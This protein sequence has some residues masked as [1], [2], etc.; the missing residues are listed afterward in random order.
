MLRVSNRVVWGTAVVA[1]AARIAACLLL[2]GVARA[3]ETAH[4]HGDLA[5]HLLAG[6]GFVF[7][8]YTPPGGLAPSSQQ[9]PFVAGLLA[10]CGGATPAWGGLDG[11]VAWGLMLTLQIAASTATAALLAWTCLRLRPPAAAWVG[12]GAAL[13]PPLVVAPLHVQAVVWN[14]FWLAL[15]AAGATAW[16]DHPRLAGLRM[17]VVAMVGGLHT[18]PVLLAPSA[19][20]ALFLFWETETPID[21]RRLAVAGAV[22]AAAL[23]PWTARNYAVHG[24]LMLVKD[25]LPYV[26]WQGNNPASLGTD[27][28]LV[29]GDGRADVAGAASAV[30]GVRAALHARRSAKSV[31]SVL[32]AAQ[33]E[34]LGA[35]PDEPAR[36]AWFGA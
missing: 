19:V 20:V 35:L 15:L 12:A 26:L 1:L 23:V 5:R 17:M 3:P 14:L 18:D 30:D 7:H 11:S 29:D 6:R 28:L 21:R 32:T 8:F 13:Y 33:V 2:D 25:S 34:T 10:M 24:R 16:R 9:A 4:E 31:D 36:M 22:V 27:K